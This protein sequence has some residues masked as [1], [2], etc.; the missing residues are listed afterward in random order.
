MQSQQLPT[1]SQVFE[2]E[3][4][5]GTE[6]ADYQAEEMPERHD[7]GKNFSGKDRIK[8]CAKSFISQVY[9]L[10]ARHSPAARDFHRTAQDGRHGPGSGGDGLARR[11]A[12][13]R[14]RWFEP[15]S[16]TGVPGGAACTLLLR[17][18]GPLQG[19]AH[20]AP[21]YRAGPRGNAAR[22][23][24]V[25]SLS[26]R[27]ILY[28]RGTG[29]G[30]HRALTRGAPHVDSGGQGVLLVRERPRAD[31]AVGGAGS[32]YQGGRT[33]HGKHRCGYGP[34]RAGHH[35]ASPATGVAH[36]GG[37]GDPRDVCAD[38]WHGR[39]H[40]EQRT[41]GWTGKGS[42]GRAHTREV[43]LGCVFTPTKLD[44]EGWPVPDEDSTTYTGAIET[45]EEFSRRLYTEAQ[46]RGWDRA[47]KK[48][49]MGDGAE[50]IWNRT[51]EIFPG[52]TEIVDLY[53]ARQHLW[54]LSSKLHPNEVAAKRRWVMSH[55]HLLDDG[56]IELLA[57]RLRALGTERQ[58]LADDIAT[59]A[60]Y[61]ERNAAR[62]RYPKFRQQG[63]FVGSGVI[64]AGCKTLIGS[65]LKRS[66]MFW[67]V[68]GANAVIA[69]RCCRHSREFDDYWESR[70]A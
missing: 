63:L 66:G 29:C 7:H 58:E 67:T 9:D 6:S 2:D 55:Q 57:N 36:G 41:G 34:P 43:K 11:P 5:A 26:E 49:V 39:T 20:Q 4:L 56:K 42:N 60:N 25:L 48:V 13:G 70:R 30:E 35:P 12:A 40:G 44:A 16:P 64:E 28:R 18:S 45:A 32:H 47:Q 50:W 51:Q 69:V 10:L 19:D 27:A 8:L 52:A 61:F 68:R 65:R 62:M 31:E 15:T 17:R 1:E 21:A 24:L 59:E 37:P 33:D 53:H 38:G 23:L 22:L 54:D 14:C 46:Q 3:V